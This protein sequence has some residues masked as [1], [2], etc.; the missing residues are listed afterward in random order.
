MAF[1]PLCFDKN[2]SLLLG[3]SFSHR[4]FLKCVIL[5]CDLVEHSSYVSCLSISDVPEDAIIHCFHSNLF[6]NS[7]ID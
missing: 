7:A 1:L 5:L 2:V 4:I 3:A 6:L